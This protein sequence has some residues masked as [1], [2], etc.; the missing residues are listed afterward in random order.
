MTA[1]LDELHMNQLDSEIWK[2]QFDDEDDQPPAP[3]SQRHLKSHFESK[4]QTSNSKNIQNKEDVADLQNI[5]SQELFK[6]Q[7]K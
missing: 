2:N 4:G 5:K 7:T 3:D 6:K 1:E